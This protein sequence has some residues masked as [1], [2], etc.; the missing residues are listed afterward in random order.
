MQIHKP[1]TMGRRNGDRLPQ[2]KAP[3][4]GKTR[5]PGLALTFIRQ[6]NHMRARF[7]DFTGKEFINRGH[8]SAGINHQ[9]RDI[10]LFNRHFGLT[11]HPVFKRITV[12]IFK[13][14]GVYHAKY[15]PRQMRLTLAPVTR[16]PRLIINN[17]MLS[18]DQP[19]KQC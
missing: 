11:A 3:A 15:K 13:P 7:A 16:D 10:S 2:S 19:V 17:G 12:C 4:I 5:R 9:K 6:Q 1:F 8:A 14:G 18:P